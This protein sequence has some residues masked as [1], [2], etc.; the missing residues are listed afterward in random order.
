[1]IRGTL[2]ERFAKRQRPTARYSDLGGIDNVLKDIRGLQ[3][4]NS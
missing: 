2:T 4:T 3:T 1:M